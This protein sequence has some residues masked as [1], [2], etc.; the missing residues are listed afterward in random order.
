VCK[1]KDKTKKA[2]ATVTGFLKKYVHLS[3]SGQALLGMAKQAVNNITN[4]QVT[5]PSS[6][7]QQ[8]GAD[9]LKTL[10]NYAGPALAIAGAFGGEGAEGDVVETPEEGEEATATEQGTDGEATAESA[11]MKRLSSG[12]IEKL[13]SND[14]HPH[15]LKPNSKYDLFKNQNGDVFVKPRSGTGPGEPTGI[16]LKELK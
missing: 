10:G 16:N 8:A 7:L 9:F 14:I 15:D 1:W 11:Q 12:D 5:T 2:A 6:A 13:R 3:E 4:K